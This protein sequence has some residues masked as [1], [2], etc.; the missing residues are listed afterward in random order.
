MRHTTCSVAIVTLMLTGFI[1]GRTLDAQA[2]GSATKSTMTAKLVDPEKKAA[3]GGATVEVT[4]SGVELTDPAVANE[5][6]VAGQ[7]HLHYQVD[8][9]PVIATPT[10]KLS[11]HDLAPGSHTITVTLVSNDHKPIG[12]HQTLTVNVPKAMKSTAGESKPAETAPTSKP[13]Y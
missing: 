2:P 11:F 4:T 6:P 7:G 10:A 9:G 3:T 1:A 13:K 8:K 5:K 12:P